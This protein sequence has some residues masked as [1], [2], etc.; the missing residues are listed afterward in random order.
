[1][2]SLA[3]KELASRRH[4][5]DRFLAVIRP[6]DSAKTMEAAT[7]KGLVFVQLYAMY[8]YAVRSAVQATLYSIKRQG[9]SCGELRRELLALVLNARWDSAAKAGRSRT[10]ERR[11]ELLQLVGSNDALSELD[12]TLFPSDGSHY[13]PDQLRTVWKVIGLDVPIVAHRRHLGRIEELVENR[14][15]IAHGRI[16]AQDV[17]RRY[18][19]DELEVRVIDTVDICSYVVNTIEGHCNTG[20]LA[21]SAS[22]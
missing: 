15:A 11:I 2:F 7:C 22:R 21:L 9:L 4:D 3:K 17:G 16:T 20:K 18:S 8:E 5:L 13:R 14:N 6:L 19:P 10:W 12:D 1:M